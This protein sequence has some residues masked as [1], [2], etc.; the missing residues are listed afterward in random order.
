DVTPG[1]LTFYRRSLVLDAATLARIVHTVQTGG[2]GLVLISSW[3]AV[4]RGLI[5]DENDN[6]G[7]VAVVE[8]VKAAARTTGV[9][10]L[11]DAH[12]GKGED[13]GDEADPSRAMRGASAAA[14]AAD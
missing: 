6:A 3:Q 14:G 8:A 13:Q 10:W 11:I 1:V 2:Y 12:S 5:K 7:A 9:P 4:V